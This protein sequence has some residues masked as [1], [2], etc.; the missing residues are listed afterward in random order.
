ML[1]VWKAGKIRTWQDLR[2]LSAASGY[3]S[4]V[5]WSPIRNALSGRAAFNK[6]F[7]RRRNGETGL[8]CARLLETGLKGR[9]QVSQGDETTF[10]FYGSN[11]CPNRGQERRT[12]VRLCYGWGLDSSLGLWNTF[13]MLRC[14]RGPGHHNTHNLFKLL[15]SHT[16]CMM[17]TCYML[18]TC[19]L[20][21]IT[22]ANKRSALW[23]HDNYESRVSVY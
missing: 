23:V 6:W 17:H 16:A 8:R 10:D 22:A 9:Q 20:E 1:R 3:P 18:H 21:F 19:S 11:L 15:Y 13:K 4:H 2:D 5:H 12:T 7:S 14:L